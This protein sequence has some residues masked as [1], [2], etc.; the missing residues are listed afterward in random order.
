MTDQGGHPDPT[1][2]EGQAFWCDPL[3][4]KAGPAK[5]LDTNTVMAGDVEALQSE[6]V[7]K[8]HFRCDTHPG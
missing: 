3:S 4:P 2:C 8:C 5:P 7:D 6:G 1:V